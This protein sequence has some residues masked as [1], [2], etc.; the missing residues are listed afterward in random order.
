[1]VSA[2]KCLAHHLMVATITFVRVARGCNARVAW[3]YSNQ[4]RA[5]VGGNVCANARAALV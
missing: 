4:R 5:S 2:K 1:M 3:P